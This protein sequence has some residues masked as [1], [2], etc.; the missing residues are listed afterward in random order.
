M[1]WQEEKWDEIATQSFVFAQENTKV[2]HPIF[3]TEYIFSLKI[4]LSLKKKSFFRFGKGTAGSHLYQPAFETIK[5]ANIQLRGKIQTR[6]RVNVY[7][8]SY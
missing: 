3:S 6:E 7:F 8:I 4:Q 1:L 5:L 2:L